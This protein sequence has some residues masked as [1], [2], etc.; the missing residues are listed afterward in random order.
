MAAETVDF[1]V[2]PATLDELRPT[3]MALAP[4]MKG[5]QAQARVQQVRVVAGA[6]PAMRPPAS[7]G[8]Q[9][10]NMTMKRVSASGA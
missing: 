9:H 2:W 6:L 4:T 10:A 8:R 3:P 5:Q 1:L 7:A